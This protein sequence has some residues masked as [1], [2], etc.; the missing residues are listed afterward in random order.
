MANT[1]FKALGLETGDS[2][3]EDDRVELAGETL[4]AH[5]TAL[6]AAPRHAPSTV[7]ELTE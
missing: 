1:F 6:A 3:V 5:G 4:A 2:L 7:L